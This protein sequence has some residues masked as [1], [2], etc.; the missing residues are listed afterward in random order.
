MGRIGILVRDDA[1]LVP[2]EIPVVRMS[3]S[4]LTELQNYQD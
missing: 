4:E 1:A 2:E 3:V